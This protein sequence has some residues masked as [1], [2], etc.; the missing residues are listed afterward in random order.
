MPIQRY[1]TWRPWS[2]AMIILSLLVSPTAIAKAPS[3]VKVEDVVRVLKSKLDPTPADLAA[4]G[5]G[6]ANTLAD[7]LA[8]TR[9]DVEL[10]VRAARALGHYPGVQARAVLLTTISNPEEPSPV[11]AAAMQGLVGAKGAEALGDL[12]DYLKN[13]S[14][15]L[16]IGAA[17]AIAALGGDRART[18]LMN[19]LHHEKVIEVRVA[20]DEALQTMK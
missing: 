16:R 1:G 13:T 14:P 15:P 19:T 4:A 3:K 17:R 7:L 18:L 9:L 20:I 10:R 11:R 2:L 5:S 8:R 6:V 12:E